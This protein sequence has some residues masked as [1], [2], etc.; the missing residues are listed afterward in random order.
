MAERRRLTLEDLDSAGGAAAV[1]QPAL[2]AAKQRR[3]LNLK[4][5]GMEDKPPKEIPF[6]EGSNLEI[7]HPLGSVKLKLSGPEARFFAGAGKRFNEIG[8]RVKQLTGNTSPDDQAEIDAAMLRDR[9]LLDTSAG[10]FGYMAPD[11]V[12]GAKLPVTPKAALGFGAASGA[13]TPLTSEEQDT[14]AGLLNPTIGALGAGLGQTG[15]GALS[16]FMGRASNLAP[17]YLAQGTNLA[18]DVARRK[19]LKVPQ[20]PVPRVPYEDPLVAATQDLASSQGVRTSIGDLD[21]KSVW[22]GVEDKLEGV[23]PNRSRFL[24]GQQSDLKAML[25]N[26]RGQIEKPILDANGQR[27]PDSFAMAKGLKDK[28]EANRKTARVMFDDVGNLAQQ[29]G[30]SPIAPTE[31]QATALALMAER[32]AFFQE[33]QDY[34]LWKK[35]TGVERDTGPQNSI[36]LQQNGLPFQKPQLLDFNEVKALRSRLGSEFNSAKTTDREKARVFAKLL[37]SLDQDLDVWGQNT[38][39]DAL[40]KAYAGARTYY[41][42]NVVP[43]TDPT[44]NPSKSPLFSNVA[45]KDKV[46]S[47]TIPRGVFKEDR[48]QLA[49]DFMDLATPE[50]QQAGKNALVNDIV[51]AGLNPNTES[52]LSTSI[53]RHGSRYSEPGAAVFTSGEQQ[54]LDDA[55]STLKTTRRAAA[56]TPSM[57]KTG[58]RLVPFATGAAM[59]GGASVPAY[60]ALNATLGEEL[61]PSERVAAAFGLIPMAGYAGGLGAVRYAQSQL[62]KNLHFADPKAML[63][64]LRALQLGTERGSKGFGARLGS[65]AQREGMRLPQ[66]LNDTLEEEPTP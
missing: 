2:D 51:D 10:Q 44:A 6:A 36:I 33:L 32:P 1:L 7:P 59:L 21:P 45:V 18:A 31:T 14:Y 11:I 48:Q 28:Y 17:H 5:L 62:G 4:D 39:N 13:A 52:G 55:I 41:K 16:R 65:A 19:G 3:M 8:Q 43:Y 34:G 30:V 27:V 12:A 20:M 35:L 29:P 53:V 60:Y 15:L 42:Q 64:G 61:S 40:N 54:A 63:P 57:P 38:G 25:E 56:H 23:L 47:D 49:Q 37:S 9:P 26:T 22:R 46:D 58:A 24:E 66:I 50:G